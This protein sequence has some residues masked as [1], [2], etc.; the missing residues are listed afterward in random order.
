ML[1]TDLEPSGSTSPELSRSESAVA[2]VESISTAPGSE[3]KEDVE[4]IVVVPPAIVEAQDDP[5][6]SHPSLLL[7][8]Q[9]SSA[10][11]LIPAADLSQP[12]KAEANQTPSSQPH[13]AKAEPEIEVEDYGDDEMNDTYE[14][15]S[16]ATKLLGDWLLPGIAVAATFALIYRLGM[17]TRG[18]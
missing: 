11:S 16:V 12:I 2:D 13:S 7:I 4:P 9:V 17:A 6:K 5:C 14:F 1:F 10:S 18:R 3:D 15:I 8:S